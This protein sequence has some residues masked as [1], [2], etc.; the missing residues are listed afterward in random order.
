MLI[1]SVKIITDRAI[2]EG[3]TWDMFIRD[4]AGLDIERRN[5]ALACLRFLGPSCE[6]VY[7]FMREGLFR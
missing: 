3:P 6:T 2:R 5:K 1:R 7:R 4:I